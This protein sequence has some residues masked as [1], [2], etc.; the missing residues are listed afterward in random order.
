[1]LRPDLAGSTFGLTEARV[2]YE[3]AH[4]NGVSASDLRAALDLDAGYLSRILGAFS[5]AGLI[6]RERSTDDGRRQT[7]RL[8]DDGRRAFAELDRLQAQAIDTLLTPLDQAQ[9]QELVTSMRTIKRVLDAPG[10]RPRVIIRPPSPATSAGSWSVT[11]R[12][13]PRSTAGMPPSKPWS[14]ASSPTSPNVAVPPAKPAGS[15]RW[16]TPASARCSARPP[17]NQTPRS[18]GCCWSS[19]RPA[20]SASG[21][22]WS[23]NA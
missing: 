14:P 13:T 4:S 12:A 8:T 2:L 5:T 11:A 19:R 18:Y 15:R 3:L 16:T 9:R 1:M 23:T 10:P 20:D 6:V 7:I 17:T 22:G 21:R